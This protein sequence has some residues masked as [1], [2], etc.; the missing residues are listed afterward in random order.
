MVNKELMNILKA[1]SENH[2]IYFE[3]ISTK[4]KENIVAI[5]T[6]LIKI[7]INDKN[8]SNLREMITAV[9]T[10]YIPNEEKIG[11]DGYKIEN[12]IK[13]NFI[14]IKPKNIYTKENGKLNSKLN[15]SGNFTDFR[16]AKLE[17]I[18]KD[19][20]YM[21]IS[22]FSHGK[23]V[24]ILKFKFNTNDFLNKLE[25]QL[26]KRFPEKKDIEGQW[27]RSA[28][29]GFKDYKNAESLELIYKCQDIENHKKEITKNLYEWLTNNEGK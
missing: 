13:K 10:G 1:Y 20:I 25:R 18:K 28:T 7:T 3:L 11:Y 19:D 14:E 12:G 26:I 16:W 29:F 6:D 8:S 21:V 27:L 17:R 4:S 24:Y 5:L 22:G 15:G 9:L 23:I 2:N